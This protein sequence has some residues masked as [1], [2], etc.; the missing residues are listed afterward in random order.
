MTGNFTGLAQDQISLG[1]HTR[2]SGLI[3]AVRV[4]RLETKP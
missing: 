3:E 1:A 2:M 4:K